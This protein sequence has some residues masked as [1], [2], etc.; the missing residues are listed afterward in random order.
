MHTY[1]LHLWS[2]FT[3]FWDGGSRIALR[4]HEFIQWHSSCLLCF[5]L[6]ILQF[7]MLYLSLLGF[8]YYYWELRWHI[9]RSKFQGLILRISWKAIILYV[10]LGSF[11]SYVQ[12][13]TLQNSLFLFHSHLILS[14]SQCSS[15]ISCS[16]P[17][18]FLL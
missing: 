10:D 3:P 17:F 18:P 5:L 15:T 2:G 9:H 12:F 11:F 16:H 6:L 8:L 7:L 13:H 4:S 1:Y 14:T